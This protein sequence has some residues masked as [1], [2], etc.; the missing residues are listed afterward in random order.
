[1]KKKKAKN[2]KDKEGKYHKKD[3]KVEK[4]KDSFDNVVN[5]NF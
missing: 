4:E 5:P 1:M 2:N 3:N